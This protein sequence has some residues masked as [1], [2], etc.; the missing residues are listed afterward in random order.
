MRFEVKTVTPAE[1]KTELAIVAVFTGNEPGSTS[2]ALD[3]A[4]NG[5]ISAALKNGDIKGK[6]G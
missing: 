5:A 3:K 4:T 2:K 6:A 1:H